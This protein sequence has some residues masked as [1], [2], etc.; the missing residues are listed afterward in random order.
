[1]KKKMQKQTE[2]ETETEYK[3]FYKSEWS[4]TETLYGH[5]IL[6][7]NGF[8]SHKVVFPYFV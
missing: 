3:T 5:M 8:V 6:S 2:S 7:L 4:Y 1:M